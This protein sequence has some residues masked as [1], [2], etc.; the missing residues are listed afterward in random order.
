MWFLRIS[1]FRRLTS[2]I[3]TNHSWCP[4]TQIAYT[5][6]HFYNTTL[7]F[8]N[9]CIV[10]TLALCSRPRQRLARVLAKKRA[11]E[12]EDEDSHS[13]V[14]FHYG[15][16]NLGGLPNLQR[17][18]VEVKTPRIEDLFINKMKLTW[19]CIYWHSRLEIHYKSILKIIPIEIHFDYEFV[20][21]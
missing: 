13:Q 9:V 6:L 20:I 7:Y 19:N 10:A 18:I 21:L 16:W 3:T 1:L 2:L 5:S 4:F 15:S 11:R 17:A 12:C 8:S 14:S